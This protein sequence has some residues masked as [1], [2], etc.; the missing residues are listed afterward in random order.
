MSS[1]FANLRCCA[2]LSPLNPKVQGPRAGRFQLRLMHTI[3][4]VPRVR[5]KCIDTRAG[6]RCTVTL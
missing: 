2:G 5:Y 3:P 6:P 1:R 4:W